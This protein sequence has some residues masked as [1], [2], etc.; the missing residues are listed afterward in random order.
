MRRDT[1]WELQNRPLGGVFDRNRHN[2]SIRRPD[3]PILVSLLFCRLVNR[4]ELPAVFHS[5]YNVGIAI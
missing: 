4:S 2:Q 3:F 1:G 5:G